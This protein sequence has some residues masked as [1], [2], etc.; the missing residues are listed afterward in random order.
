MS[1]MSVNRWRRALAAGGREALASRGAGGAKCKLTPAQVAELGRCWTRARRHAAMRI[2]AD[3]GAGRGPGLA[4]VRGGVH[5]GR[6]GR[7]AA[8]DRVVRAGPGPPG[9]G[10][11][12]GQDRQVAGGDLA[13]HKSTAADLGAWL[14]REDES[15]QG[16]RP[17]K[18]RTWG[19][20][21]HTPVVTATGG[22][23][24][25]VSL[26]ALI[27]VRPG[28]RPR[29]IWRTHRARRGDTRK[30]FTETDYARLLDAAHQQLDGPVVLVWDGLNTHVSRAMAELVA[31]WDWL[32]CNGGDPPQAGPCHD[33]RLRAV[34]DVRH[35]QQAVPGR[36]ES[37]GH[38]V[39]K[40]R[41]H[42]E[43]LRGN[44]GCEQ[45]APVLSHPGVQQHRPVPGV[46]DHA[47]V[48]VV[49]GQLHLY[50]TTSLAAGSSNSTRLAP[51]DVRPGPVTRAV[52]TSWPEPRM[53]ALSAPGT[54]SRHWVSPST[55]RLPP[56]AATTR[57]RSG[58]AV[59]S[60]ASGGSVVVLLN[61][62]RE[63]GSGL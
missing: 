11:G 58:E 46:H 6:D 45:L 20:R 21:G 63:S 3:F 19:R 14:C 44:A 62:P 9:R 17:P 12:R 42:A 53:A 57:R 50:S 22:H 61:S 54:A 38:H 23:D 39:L 10:A 56:A 5:A 36:I 15:G 41:A 37:A 34:A 35:E 32:G 59:S 52:T 43:P 16:L 29:L 28:C 27:A 55:I 40:D 60:R 1:R 51:A 49:E 47:D 30:G 33:G 31:A 48:G 2:R 24:T 7:A 26:A 4:A 8:P 18:G 13:G 25:R